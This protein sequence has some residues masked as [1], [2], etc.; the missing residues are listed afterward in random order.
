VE[1]DL[2]CP[3]C[4]SPRLTSPFHVVG[5]VL[6]QCRDCGVEAHVEPCTLRP[7]QA[8]MVRREEREIVERKGVRQKWGLRGR[9]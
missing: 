9:L 3:A 4:S 2:T 6:V 5:C 1:G 7:D 8:V